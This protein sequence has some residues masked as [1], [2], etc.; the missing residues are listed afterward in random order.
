MILSRLLHLLLTTFR[1]FASGNN[2]IVGSIPSEF[3]GLTSLT[4]LVIIGKFCSCCMG[5][6]PI[7]ITDNVGLT[8]SRVTN[9]FLYLNVLSLDK[10]GFPTSNTL[11]G[12]IPAELGKLTL[13]TNLELSKCCNCCLREYDD[14]GAIAS[15]F[16]T[17]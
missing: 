8:A 13:L 3:G 2:N 6:Y 10:F 1:R 7:I 17:N 4:S 9:S 15:P 14:I 5:E 11:T 12:T 16:L